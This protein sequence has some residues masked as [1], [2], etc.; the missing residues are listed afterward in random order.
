MTTNA[1]GAGG[2]GC[3]VVLGYPQE[4]Q[5]QP[6]SR[7]P[8]KNDK[9]YAHRSTGTQQVNTTAGTSFTAAA[10][11]PFV[12]SIEL[13]EQQRPVTE[14]VVVQCSAIDEK[15]A[16]TSVNRVLYF[17]S[18]ATSA[19]AAAT[20]EE[21]NDSK[22]IDPTLTSIEIAVVRRSSDAAATVTV[23][24][25][26][27]LQEEHV[28]LLNTRYCHCISSQAATTM[29]TTT[30]TTTLTESVKEKH[31]NNRLPQCLLLQFRK[32]NIQFRIFSLQANQC[33]DE[34]TEIFQNVMDVFKTFHSINTNYNCIMFPMN[35]E[36]A[37]EYRLSITPA[38]VDV[39]DD[40]NGLHQSNCSNTT[41]NTTTTGS[42]S[43]TIHNRQMDMTVV[44]QPQH[45][46]HNTVQHP[47]TAL[48]PPLPPKQPHSVQP[49]DEAVD[50][51][52]TTSS[53]ILVK[54][55]NL[56]QR[57]LRVRRQALVSLDQ[58]R[59]VLHMPISSFV[60]ASP[61]TTSA[62]Q[63]IDH[64]NDKDMDENH[65]GDC[66]PHT[67]ENCSNASHSH[68]GNID[69]ATSILKS[70]KGYLPT[71]LNLSAQLM[72]QSYIVSDTERHTIQ[73]ENDA[74]LQQLQ[75]EQIDIVLNTFFVP[76]SRHQL[77]RQKRRKLHQQQQHQLISSTINSDNGSRE[78]VVSPITTT[79]RTEHT[80]NV[81][82]PYTVLETTAPTS[83]T[84]TM[85]TNTTI[86][87]MKKLMM[88]QKRL[89]QERYQ[90][91][92]LPSRGYN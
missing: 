19:S 43:T 84:P 35:L 38:D 62:T 85:T 47:G 14:D 2:D 63:K 56:L 22:P 6:S 45:A 55:M 12:V 72:S 44:R 15:N 30:T 26:L 61:T 81:N 24:V 21:S 65:E 20:T 73:A 48:P 64:T 18:T 31:R 70:T 1:G 87:T 76:S 75:Q 9:Y 16:T 34:V 37:K 74:K 33:D 39:E 23:E 3:Q 68:D 59:H 69:D 46:R 78:T 82:N 4:V 8:K 32:T 86:G 27:R 88:E 40:E 89:I 54:K 28:F 53:N 71:L 83:A 11:I 80:A 91:L 79:I 60:S 5:G 13:F 29:T 67:S 66:S 57:H 25:Y 7:L 77:H 90:L 52:T 49:K 17:S 41:T 36:I 10:P 58:I 50:I 42:S 51:I 92:L